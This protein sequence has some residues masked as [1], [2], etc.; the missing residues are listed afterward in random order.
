M[1]RYLVQSEFGDIIVEVDNFNVALSIYAYYLIVE[2]RKVRI[3]DQRL[4]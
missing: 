2:G 3:I 1:N 4:V